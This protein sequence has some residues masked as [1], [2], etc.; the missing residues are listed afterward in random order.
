M[1]RKFP[2]RNLVVLIAM[3]L[4]LAG[5]NGE[6]QADA[7]GSS[8]GPSRG[9]ARL[10]EVTV[11]TVGPE[12]IELHGASVQGMETTRIMAKV[13]GYVES[14]STINNQEVDIGS[15][16]K[17]GDVL[18]VVNVPEMEDQRQEKEALVVQARSSVW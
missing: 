4:L 6:F 15:S 5:C 9:V 1:M 11:Y 8:P 12:K 2:I 10:T 13:G 7:T 3:V 17:Q 14:I 16:V 18:A